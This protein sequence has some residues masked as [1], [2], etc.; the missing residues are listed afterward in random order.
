MSTS[1]VKLL[2]QQQR[3][4]SLVLGHCH[5]FHLV[6]TLVDFALLEIQP[7]LWATTSVSDLLGHLSENMDTI[8]SLK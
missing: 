7:A 3:F 1:G 4:H 8:G 2:G 6:F 5:Y